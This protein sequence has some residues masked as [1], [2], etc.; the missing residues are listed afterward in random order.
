MWH[1]LKKDNFLE[2]ELQQKNFVFYRLIFETIFNMD[3][4]FPFSLCSEL[5]KLVY[6]YIFVLRFATAYVAA[7][8]GSY[9]CIYRIHGIGV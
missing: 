6:S 8:H 5:C 1:I 4:F 2:N 9:P 3:I 7:Y